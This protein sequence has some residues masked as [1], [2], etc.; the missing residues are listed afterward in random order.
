LIGLKQGNIHQVS[1]TAG[2]APECYGLTFN[3]NR[4]DP[5]IF[6]M[7]MKTALKKEQLIVPAFGLFRWL[8][9]HLM[10]GQTVT[11]PAIRTDH[12]NNFRWGDEF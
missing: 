4:A 5:N 8:R 3:M 7:P 6:R 12:P 1:A 9:G 2:P 10:K 11:H